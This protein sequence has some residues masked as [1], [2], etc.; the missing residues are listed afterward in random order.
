M[1]VY[2]DS[3][4]ALRVLH[5]MALNDDSDLAPL[6]P[7]L[8][9]MVICIHA[10]GV[11][12]QAGAN[13]PQAV[14][15]VAAHLIPGQGNSPLLGSQAAT[16]GVAATPQDAATQV[17]NAVSA[18]SAENAQQAA[19]TAAAALQQMPTTTDGG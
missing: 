12:E 5:G 19:T 15:A 2:A 14:G 8:P 18:A 6:V 13:T 9:L 3:D 17:T 1:E 10:V 4:E 16:T 7:F 11:V